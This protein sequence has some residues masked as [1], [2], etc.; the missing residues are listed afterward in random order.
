MSYEPFDA[1]VF[2][3]IPQ[4][5]SSLKY[6]VRNGEA[7]EAIKE[8][9][10]VFESLSKRLAVDSSPT[11]L[12]AFIETI[13]NDSVEDLLDNPAYT[14]QLGSILIS[15]A[16]AHLASFRLISPKL[17]QGI[18]RALSQPKSSAHTKSLL[19]VLNNLLRIRRQL[20]S[21]LSGGPSAETYEDGP[22]SLLRGVFFKVFNENAVD[23]PT[24]QQVELSQ[25]ALLGLEQIVKQRRLREDGLGLTTDCDE[26]AFQEICATLSFRYLNCFNR[27]APNAGSTQESFESAVG[28]SLLAAVQYYPQGYGKIVSDVLDDVKKTNWSGNPAKRSRTALTMSCM[29]LAYLGCAV[30]PEDAAAVANFATFAGSM[31]KTLGIL[32]ASKASFAACTP[33]AVAILQGIRSFMTAEEVRSHLDALKQSDDWEKSW[34]VAT[35]D[36]AVKEML[37]AFPDLA[38]GQFDQFDQMS[39]AQVLSEAP[40]SGKQD[41]VLSF[42]Q[43]SVFI[44]RQLYQHATSQSDI[45]GVQLDL[46]SPLTTGLVDVEGRSSP[47]SVLWRDRYLT[48]VASIAATVLREL[49]LSAQKDLSLHT[50]MLTCFGP[51]K[52]TPQQLSWSYHRA[53][54]L[55]ELSWGIALAIRPEV[56]LN[57]VSHTH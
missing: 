52:D 56:V 3:Y 14:E 45:S 48:M 6:E 31:L 50:Q 40:K 44:V 57:L 33:V 28:R 19:L 42:L 5:W 8:T 2:S 23:N 54:A 13:W 53:A 49:N 29:R 36:T 17:S 38:T 22:V 16:R 35:I 46:S 55:S 1:H 24:A 12:K 34:D 20:A 30:V 43:L 21:S 25:E 41:F 32:F 37:P 18:Q 9:L 39:V 4:I 27:R 26:A 7:P 11:N 15:A 51:L 47:N 10:S